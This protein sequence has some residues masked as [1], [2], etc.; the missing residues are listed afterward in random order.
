M[1]FNIFVSLFLFQVVTVNAGP[2]SEK[3]QK[4]LKPILTY[5]IFN[6][7]KTLSFN[8]TQE[9][10]RYAFY[11]WSPIGQKRFEEIPWNETNASD[12]K[13][14]FN[15]FN[16]ASVGHALSDGEIWIIDQRI[17]KKYIPGERIDPQ[18]KDITLIAMVHIQSILIWNNVINGNDY[19]VTQNFNGIYILPTVIKRNQS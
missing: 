5:S 15:A 17:F 18:K 7:P 11:Q 6:S 9:S 10:F 3:A 8:D 14:I 19:S 13:I 1:L 4:W 12:M 2:A 16:G